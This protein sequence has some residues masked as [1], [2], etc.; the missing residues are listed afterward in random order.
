[1]NK[2][3]NETGNCIF[4]LC[5]DFARKPIDQFF[6]IIDK[7]TVPKQ[8]QKL[9]TAIKKAKSTRNYGPTYIGFDDYSQ[10]TDNISNTFEKSIQTLRAI[11]DTPIKPTNAS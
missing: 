3:D 7:Q 10:Y 2:I 8:N 11:M 4:G 9:F 5:K 1:M 6:K